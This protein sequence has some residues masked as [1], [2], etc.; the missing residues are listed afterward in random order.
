MTK[1]DRETR[2]NN[3][4]HK[5]D[6]TYTYERLG[7]ITLDE[8][9]QAIREDL[10]ALREEFGVSFLNG[11]ELIIRATNEYGDPVNVRRLSNG[12]VVHRLDTHH[13][14]PACLDYHL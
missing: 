4:T 8:Q 7:T 10:H 5:T 11:V 6:L 3:K 13:Y 1:K 12:A 2:N 14:R 9:L